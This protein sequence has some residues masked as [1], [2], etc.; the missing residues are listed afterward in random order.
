MPSPSQPGQAPCGLLNENSRGSSSG[1]RVAADR[2]GELVR[3]QQFLALRL[4]EEGDPRDALAEAERGLEGF[5]QPLLEIGAH[6]EPVDDRL[7]RVLALGIELRRGVELDVLAVDA[8]AHETLAAQLLDHLQ[9]LALA[10][11]DDRGEQGER[12][13]FG[14]C[15]HLVDHLAHGL[16][17]EVEPVIRAARNAGARK[18]QA[19]VIVDLGDRADGR[20][21]IVR[22]R[23]LLD[24]DR[25][26]QA[27]DRIDVR[28]FHHRQE[29]PR[30]GR[31]RLDIAALAF[32]IDRV[33]GE[34]GFSRARQAG[35]H[36]QPVARQLEVE[37]PEVVR[38]RAADVDGLCHEASLIE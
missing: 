7:D 6:L 17:R 38:A 32:G 24:R 21:R 23:F 25:G 1:Q 15:Q 33:E 26:R 4:V 11:G 16:G 27:L 8:R 36:D 5:G 31:Q 28:L 10:A 22:G 19:Q 3:E 18:Q 29:L 35:E 2:A 30:I 37:S 20:A 14:Q 13:A 34:R 12:R 9:V